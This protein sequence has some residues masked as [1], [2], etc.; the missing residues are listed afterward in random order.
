MGVAGNHSPFHSGTFAREWRARVLAGVEGKSATGDHATVLFE[1]EVRGRVIPEESLEVLAL[2]WVEKWWC[3]AI[4]N[5]QASAVVGWG[6]GADG[7]GH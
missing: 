6:V 4:K 2:R 3:V 7:G 1:N 5:V